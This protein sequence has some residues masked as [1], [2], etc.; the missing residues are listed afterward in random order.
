MSLEEK[1][2]WIYAVIAVV[3]PAVYFTSVLT[4]LPGTD[5][6]RIA[7][8]RPLLTAVGV[9]IVLNIIAHMVAAMLSPKDVGP[10]DERE[11]QI[12]RLGEYV[13]FF[14]MSIASVLPL[15]LAMIEAPHF[16][17]ANTLYLAFVLA[18]LTS[19]IVKIVA[20]RRGF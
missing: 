4:Q 5:A 8:V 11:K 10:K 20:H 16:W 19:S 17:I 18:A 3:V 9:A 12:D 13:G 15:V 14:V 2:A 7:Y 6:T 1:R